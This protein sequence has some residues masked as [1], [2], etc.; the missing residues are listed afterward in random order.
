MRHIRP[1]PHL[2][3]GLVLAATL[4]AATPASAENRCGWLSNPTPGNW[5]LADRD[6]EWVLSVQG[7]DGVPGFDNLPD[8]S[9]KGWVATNGRSYGYGC[10]CID[11]DVDKAAKRVIRMRTARPMP[12]SACRNDPALRAARPG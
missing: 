6:G 2:L 12:L 8:M 1:I 5:W 9:V 10:A 11:M 7:R 3:S 4:I